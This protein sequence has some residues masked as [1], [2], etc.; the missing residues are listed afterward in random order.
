MI[1][2]AVV[3][4]PPLLVPE[5]A[6]GA[7]ADVAP[8]LRACDDAVAALLAQAPELLVCVGDGPRTREHPASAWGTFAGLGVD[9]RAPSRSG[10]DEPPQPAL[11]LSLTVGCWLLERAGWTGR[12][13]LQEVGV[14]DEPAACAELGG[15]LAAGAGPGAA[16]LVLGDA[17]STRTEKAPGYLDL[18]AEGF[19]TAAA[20]AL[21]SGDA[22]ELARIDAGLAREVG[23]AGRAAWQVLAGAAGGQQWP[24]T[25]GL[26]YDDA[27]YGVGYLVAT[28]LP[29]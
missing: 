24:G 8:L 1:A 29:A 18:R 6:T 4:H 5:L 22:A 3:P 15:R 19:D 23:A 25:T 13:L 11:P 21:V 27:P 26:L 7:A 16:W 17:S 2:A 12:T 28:W 10:A 20:H 14:D 9:L